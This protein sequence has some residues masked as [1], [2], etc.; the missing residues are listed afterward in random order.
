MWY[1]LPWKPVKITILGWFDNIEYYSLVQKG[2]IYFSISILRGH[3]IHVI[4]IKF[5]WEI[6]WEL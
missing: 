6:E 1:P 4:E 2:Q 3:D 5:L